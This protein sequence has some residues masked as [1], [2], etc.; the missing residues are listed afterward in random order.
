M[1]VPKQALEARNMCMKRFTDIPMADAE[2]VFPDK[3]VFLRPLLVIQLSVAIIGALAAGAGALLSVRALP[4][5]RYV[6]LC[7]DRWAAC[8]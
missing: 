7:L 3:R 2:V 1:H 8:L 6:Q 5:A 4:A